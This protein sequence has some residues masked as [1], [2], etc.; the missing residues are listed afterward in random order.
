MDLVETGLG[1]AGE[2]GNEGVVDNPEASRFELVKD[3]E[4]AFLQYERDGNAIVFVHTEVPLALRGQN[5][6]EALVKFGLE[7]A[8][9]RGLKIVAVCPFVRAYLRKHPPAPR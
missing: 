7:S 9:A 5:V 1:V 2:A 3:G 4:L 6:G 8:R